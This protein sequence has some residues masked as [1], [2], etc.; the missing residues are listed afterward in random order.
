MGWAV[1]AGW[2]AVAA[3]AAADEYD[4]AI[5]RGVAARDHALESGS[6]QD[7]KEALDL[8]D[9]AT[10]VRKTKEAE[11][12][13]AE[14][15]VHLDL[16]DEAFAAYGEALD[17]GVHG[18]AE[19]RARAFL[20]QHRTQMAA[21]SV[22]GP[23]GATVIV[24]ERKRG[25]LPLGRPLVVSAGVVRVRLE[26]PR[27]QPWESNVV[28]PA[29]AT[30]AVVG[31]LV[32]DA[33]APSTVVEIEKVVVPASPVV[34]G[35]WA[36]PLLVGGALA[37]VGGGAAIVLTT[38]LSD[39]KQHTLEQQC[40]IFQGNVCTATTPGQR[41]AAQSTADDVDTLVNLRWA[42]IGLASA[43]GL[44][45]TAALFELWSARRSSGHA[46]SAGVRASDRGA[47]IEWRGAF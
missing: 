27:F 29:G 26:M 4:S 20:D 36:R 23:D 30:A 28:A 22:E 41:A 6:V 37:I 19:E 42:A 47:Y 38:V 3:P 35:Q 5:A 11:F 14:A 32:P 2:L 9:L 39:Q 21:L 25:V 31:R 43:G 1:V 8:F 15:A 10:E 46:F 13:F 18:R 7:W 34:A 17:L 16:D 33:A 12:E 40:V 44:A 24:G 45:L